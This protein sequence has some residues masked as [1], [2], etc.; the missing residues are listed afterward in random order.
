ML[1][2]LLNGTVVTSFVSSAEFVSAS[3]RW[4]EVCG[5]VGLQVAATKRSLLVTSEEH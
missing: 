1:V 4:W 5:T 3:E 2:Q